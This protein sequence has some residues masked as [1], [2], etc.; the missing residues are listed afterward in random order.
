MLSPSV[1]RAALADH[2]ASFF[3]DPSTETAVE[4]CERNLILTR[5]TERPGAYRTDRTPFVREWLN[6]FS[7]PL[8][9]EETIV[10]CS[11]GC[12][13]TQTLLAGVCYTIA[14]RPTEIKWVH[15]TS[16][17]A[18]SLKQTRFDDLVNNCPALL[19]E[20]P[21]DSDLY[22]ALEQQFRRATLNWV[23]SNSPAKL[24]SRPIDL[25]IEDETDK[26]P[27]ASPREAD[28]ANLAEQR[29]KSYTGSKKIR[30]STPTLNNG[31]IWQ[32]WLLGDMRYY[33]MPC[34]HPGCG[35]D[36][37]FEWPRVDWDKAARTDRG[38]DY[39]R[40][41]ATARYLCPHCARAITDEDKLRMLPLGEWRP[42]VLTAPRGVRSHHI[43]SLYAPLAACSFGQLAV[44]FLK[45]KESLLGLQ[46][47]INGDL[48]EPFIDQADFDAVTLPDCS[49]SVS[50][51]WTLGDDEPP[52]TPLITV[53][54]QKDHFWVVVREWARG[55]RARPR[56]AARVESFDDLAAIHRRY[57]QL[58]NTV[59]IDCRYDRD[60]DVYRY[61]AMHRW[62][63]LMGDGDKEFYNHRDGGRSWRRIY[64]MPERIE[65]YI[66]TAHKRAFALRYFFAASTCK[67]IHMRLLLRQT[68]D[69]TLAR[70]LPEIYL[71]HLAAEK[72]LPIRDPISGVV[73]WKWTEVV[74]DANHLRD[75][76]VMQIPLAAMRGLI[77][78]EFAAVDQAAPSAAAAEARVAEQTQRHHALHTAAPFRP[79][80]TGRGFARAW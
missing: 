8:L 23:G 19:A 26:Y 55:A 38:W 30:C 2:A 54:V 67:D 46:G 61:A 51:A 20:K 68:G 40:V 12:A 7:A 41:E 35:R 58:E 5:F 71:T 43:S 22:K 37:R 42:S 80:R 16:D 47:F 74:Q 27:H 62:I 66:G 79:R 69:Y 6:F 48:A 17:D 44:R 70:D 24:A 10:A 9:S 59:G 39:Q 31:I 57:G 29:T 78:E 65:A 64:S 1:Q 33:W 36:I 77:H 75:C 45:G 28:A 25:L 34:P 76:E 73:E 13:K 4:W 52:P 11:Q 32:A 50:D 18:K 3:A 60:G 56:L 15:P 21:L 63:C 49:F 53:D 14:E 72:K